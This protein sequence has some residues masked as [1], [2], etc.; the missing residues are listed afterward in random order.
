MSPM[1]ASTA[2]HRSLSRPSPSS[3]RGSRHRYSHPHHHPR[4]QPQRPEGLGWAWLIAPAKLRSVAKKAAMRGPM[5]MQRERSAPTI[6]TPI[7]P[8]PA[9]WV[10]RNRSNCWSQFGNRHLGRSR[11]MSSMDRW[12]L[13]LQQRQRARQLPHMGPLG[14]GM[15]TAAQPPAA[16]GLAGRVVPAPAAQRKPPHW[17]TRSFPGA[18]PRAQIGPQTPRESVGSWKVV[19]QPLPAPPPTPK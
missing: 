7:A 4:S 2:R 8:Q 16:A 10:H 3:P 14:T 6:A 19:R 9:A 1:T 17:N 12:R 5:R 15:S 13:F 11:R 18:A